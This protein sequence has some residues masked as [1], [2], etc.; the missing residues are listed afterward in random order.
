MVELYP[1][2]KRKPVAYNYGVLVMS[3]NSDNALFTPI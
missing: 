3:F 2:K 1:P